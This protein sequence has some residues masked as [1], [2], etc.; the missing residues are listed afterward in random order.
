MR[1]PLIA[2]FTVLAFTIAI[3]ACSSRNAPAPATPTPA[4]SQPHASAPSPADDSPTA[5][6]QHFFHLEE[7]QDYQ[8]TYA[9]LSSR[10]KATY[11]KLHAQTALQYAELRNSS[12]TVWSHFEVDKQTQL[13]SATI[14]VTG[15][16][17][18]DSLG[19]TERVRIK[20]ILV[21]EDGIWKIDSWKY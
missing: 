7:T 18:T 8:Q 20:L 4:A 6:L 12:E 17:T 15:H 13:N 1:F 14:L 3:A 11:R 2:P 16:A 19:E 5:L 9:L 21:K 10:N